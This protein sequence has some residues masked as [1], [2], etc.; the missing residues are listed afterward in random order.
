MLH[1]I[2]YRVSK[3]SSHLRHGYLPGSSSTA[4]RILLY[5]RSA[6]LSQ[7]HHLEHFPRTSKAWSRSVEFSSA[8]ETR[9]REAVNHHR[10]PRSISTECRFNCSSFALHS[11]QD[12]HCELY[13]MSSKHGES[14]I[15]LLRLVVITTF[16]R[17]HSPILDSSAQTRGKEPPFWEG[18]RRKW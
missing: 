1:R 5:E 11:S 3:F 15:V 13:L 2:T 4:H 18:L 9:R 10:S 12:P 7:V 14:W 6:D 17:L 16:S 8:L